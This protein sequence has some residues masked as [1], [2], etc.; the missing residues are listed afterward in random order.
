M[1]VKNRY[2]GCME[3]VFRLILDVL[4]AI[5]LLTTANGKSKLL[6]EY[7]AGKQQLN[8]L[9]RKRVKAPRL[10]TL[11]RIVFA[12]SSIFISTH[13]LPKLSYIVAH[14]TLLKFHRALVKRKYSLLF[15]NKNPKNQ[16]QKGLQ[17]S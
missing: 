4:R 6:A 17:K 5:A 3:C 13:R 1:Q 15:S 2:I 8:R 7:I 9:A 11:D 12:F 10:K 16:V 14:S